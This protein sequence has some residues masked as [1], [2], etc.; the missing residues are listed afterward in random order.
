MINSIGKAIRMERITDRSTGK[1]VIVPMD[2]GVS[3]GPIKGLVDMSKTVDMVAEGGANAVIG[4]IA[5]YQ[6][7]PGLRAHIE[8][9]AGHRHIGETAG[10]L[11]HFRYPDGARNVTAAVANIYTYS[12]ALAFA[13]ESITQAAEA[14]ALPCITELA[15]SLGPWLHPARSIPL[16]LVSTRPVLG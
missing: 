5:L 12:H 6:S 3:V 4:H 7:Q 10:E 16:I 15:I 13:L 14:A 2:H 8:V 9:I 1:I 11:G